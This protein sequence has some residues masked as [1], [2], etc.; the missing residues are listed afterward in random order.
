MISI[1]YKLSEQWGIRHPEKGPST[2]L[3]PEFQEHQSP[4]AVT[5]RRTLF[6]VQ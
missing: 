1:F 6:N 3:E 4:Q 2:A 5:A